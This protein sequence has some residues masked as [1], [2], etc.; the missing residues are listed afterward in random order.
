MCSIYYKNFILGFNKHIWNIIECLGTHELFVIKL[1]SG[2]RG[3]AFKILSLF[4]VSEMYFKEKFQQQNNMCF[5]RIYQFKLSKAKM[6]LYTKQ[7]SP[8]LDEN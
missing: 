5:V 6:C 1:F 7:A 4:N 2:T 3:L 8:W